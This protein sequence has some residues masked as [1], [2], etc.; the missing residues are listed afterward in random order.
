M[1]SAQPGDHEFL[2]ER[3]IEIPMRDGTILRADVWR[4]KAE[5]KY[6]V[7]IERTP[8]DK[9]SSSESGQGAGEYY[10]S[11]GYVT[12]VQDVR[13]RFASDGDFYPFRDDGDGERQDGYDTVE[14]A[15]EQPWSNGNIGT[16]GGS[17]SGATQY[18]MIGA[19]PP[20]LKAQFVRQSA[21]DYHREWVYRS[22]AYEA[23]FNTKWT[24]T[25]T[26]SNARKYAAPGIED[27]AQS[28][29]ENALE[30][31]LEWVEKSPIAPF[32]PT[33][34]LHSWF[35]DW[36]K[37]P[38]YSDYWDEFSIVRTYDKVQVPVHHIGSWYDCFLRGTITN[39]ESMR[40]NA[41]S[42]E[43]SAAQRLTIG[44]WVHNPKPADMREAGAVDFGENTP[45]GWMETR[46][47]W[48][49]HW[50]KG[51][52]NGVDSDKPVK[53]FTMGE[54]QWHEFDQWPPA[55]VEYTSFY[56]NDSKSGSVDSL[57]DGGLSVSSPV[58]VTEP[59]SYQSDPNNPVR[60]FGGGHLG[61]DFGPQ[62]QR[63]YEDRV[64]TYTT[65]IMG[66][67]IRVTGPVK[68]VLHAS[69]SAVD[70]DWV[71]RVTDVH[72]DG[73]S[74]L[75]C[76]GILRGRYRNSFEKPELLRPDEVYE[77]EVDLWATSHLFKPGHRIRVAVA[78]SSFPRWDRN[79]QTGK[80]NAFESEG[81]V[82][83]NRVYKDA[84]RP[85]HILLPLLK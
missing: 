75:I 46:R 12:V 47:R 45:I 50:L 31:Y 28:R 25:H 24:I 71:V 33:E 4:P 17:Y 53:V 54:N 15:A 43:I 36:M 34:G 85:S 32:E 23:G 76:D 19:Q 72:P 64:L 38:D 63:G 30:N 57:N 26:A 51:I 83:T 49:D 74:M 61:E 7:L 37:R 58:A 62:D 59:D 41:P 29:M 40:D 20:H 77:F 81:V 22:G 60:S 3:N 73:T 42:D 78:S 52:D 18:R 48:F 6:P 79:W 69:S 70:T 80:N 35:N 2:V 65:E 39:Y 55:E 68:A 21:S 5:G 44:P 8:Y 27:E 1:T 10:A 56:F 82:A 84:A 67:G 14:W 9:T 66:E 16:I 13:G 11:H